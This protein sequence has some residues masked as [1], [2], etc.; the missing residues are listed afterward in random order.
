MTRTLHA[1]APRPDGAGITVTILPAAPA[2]TDLCF[3]RF[4]TPHGPAILTG[5]EGAVWGLG[6]AADMGEDSVMADLAARW[7]G[8]RLVE[9]PEALHP[10]L[11]ILMRNRGEIRVCLA[12]TPFQ[13]QVWQ[14]LLRIPQGQVVTYATLAA[15]IGKPNAARAVGS[16]VGQNPLAWIVPCHRVTRGDGG[17]GG[18][19]WGM[20]VKRSLLAAEQA[21]PYQPAIL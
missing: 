5:A 9:A 18:Y 11:H 2:P 7:P 4:Q 19:H 15:R 12:G 13:R 6:L 10:A 1:P 3:G 17:I 16:A 20:S 21:Q 14:E 8:T